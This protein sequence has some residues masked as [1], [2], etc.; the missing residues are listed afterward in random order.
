MPEKPPPDPAEHAQDFARRYREPLDWYC[1]IRIQELGI[2]ENKNGAPDF[3]RDGRWRAFDPEGRSGGNIT[4]G[5]Y[6]NSGVLNPELLKG[7]KGGRIWP[8]ARLRDRIDAI[9]AHEWAESKTTDHVAAL[10]A[11]HRTELPISDEA[12]RICRA[13]AR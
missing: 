10:R 2:P 9:I 7:K 1:T 3:D 6:L 11:A 13:M 12:R 8:K 4:S 5:I